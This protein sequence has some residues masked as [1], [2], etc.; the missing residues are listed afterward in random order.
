MYP[1]RL[2]RARPQDARAIAIIHVNSW[3]AAYAGLLPDDVLARLSVEK[4]A[5]FWRDTLTKPPS[6]TR[7]TWTWVVE[8]AGPF[9]SIVGFAFVGPTRDADLD[10]RR[11]AE[12]YAFYL[13]P[14]AWRQG[15][16]STLIDH[17]LRQLRAHSF[18]DF[19]LWALAENDR[20]SSFYTAA[21]FQR[22]GARKLESFGDSLHEE[23]R[24]RWHPPQTAHKGTAP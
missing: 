16:G 3:R 9:P 2:R 11:C 24:Y 10:P 13:D 6:P 5:D 15:Y 18:H 20:A 22:D 8:R 17:A 1:A 23:V 12:I 19:S 4:R 7:E 14:E 21:G